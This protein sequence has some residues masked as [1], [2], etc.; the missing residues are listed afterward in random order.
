M[1]A[2]E[3]AGYLVQKSID[4]NKHLTNLKLQKLLYFVQLRAI[5]VSGKGLLS[6]P[7]FEAWKFGPVISRIYDAYCLNAGLDIDKVEKYSGSVMEMPRFVDEVYE[8][9]IDASSWSMVQLAHRPDG[10][11]AKNFKQGN[12]C[13]I[14][15]RDVFNDANEM[16]P[17]LLIG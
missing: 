12:H 5:Q 9:F 13:I 17:A 2:F 4:Q 1:D 6:A 3:L 15:E 7:K 14:P 11:W 8:H 10:A 16:D